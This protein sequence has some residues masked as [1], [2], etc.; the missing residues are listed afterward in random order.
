MVTH[1]C[2]GPNDDRNEVHKSRSEIG[3]CNPPD[4]SNV[5][6]QSIHIS[7]QIRPQLIELQLC[8]QLILAR[9]YLGPQLIN[10]RFQQGDVLICCEVTLTLFDG[11]G[12]ASACLS[13]NPPAT[14]DAVAELLANSLRPD[15]VTIRLDH[16][17][18]LVPY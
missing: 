16:D 5:G 15:T 4:P 7:L 11:Q 6:T 2:D 10:V 12:I 8:S 9:L 13:L 14:D 18:T 3:T 1:Q 17:E